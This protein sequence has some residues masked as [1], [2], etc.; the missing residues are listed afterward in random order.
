MVHGFVLDAER[1]DHV[2]LKTDAPPSHAAF[3]KRRDN[4]PENPVVYEAGQHRHAIGKVVGYGVF[5]PY[6]AVKPDSAQ[7][8]VGLANIIGSRYAMALK[9]PV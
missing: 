8:I 4:R 3:R 5:D 6:C 2:L 7:R 9:I 1:T